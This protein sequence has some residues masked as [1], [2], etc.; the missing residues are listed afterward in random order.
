MVVFVVNIVKSSIVHHSWPS[1][2]VIFLFLLNDCGR[3]HFLISLFSENQIGPFLRN[4]LKTKLYIN[5]L[6]SKANS[7][8]IK[9]VEMRPICIK[10]NIVWLNFKDYFDQNFLTISYLNIL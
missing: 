10:A 4:K 2:G 3:R 8:Y 5:R 6:V 9:L 1:E 7:V